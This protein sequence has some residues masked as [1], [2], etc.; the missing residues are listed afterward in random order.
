MR[1]IYIPGPEEI[2]EK[3]YMIIPNLFFDEFMPILTPAAW[4]IM[5]YF[6]RQTYGFKRDKWSIGIDRIAIGTG[7][8]IR[9]VSTHIQPLIKA[10]LLIITR[11]AVERNKQTREYKLVSGDIYI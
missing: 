3:W 1:K 6:I 4:K 5:S 11:E 9:T 8:G 10:G 7:L 2:A